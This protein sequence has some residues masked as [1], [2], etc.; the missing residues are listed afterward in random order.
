MIARIFSAI[1]SVCSVSTVL[2]VCRKTDHVNSTLIFTKLSLGID[3]I[4]FTQNSK[5]TITVWQNYVYSLIYTS[6]DYFLSSTKYK[7]LILV[8]VDW[9]YNGTFAY[10]LYLL[11]K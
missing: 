7:Q 4:Y 3:N 10:R 5:I 8:I 11:I 1:K 9:F 6:I 2:I